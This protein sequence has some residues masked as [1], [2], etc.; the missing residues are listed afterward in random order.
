MGV[1]YS[2]EEIRNGHIP[3]VGD[4]AALG[5]SLLD[6]VGVNGSILAGVVYGSTAVDRASQ[7]SDVDVLFIYRTGELLTSLNL[8]KTALNDA[9][10]NGNFAKDEIHMEPSITLGSA[11]R[12]GVSDYISHFKRVCQNNTG[13]SVGDPLQYLDLTPVGQAEHQADVANFLAAKTE[14]FTKAAFA[15]EP[16]YKAMQRALELPVSIARKIQGLSSLSKGSLPSEDK[17]SMLSVG[18]SILLERRSRSSNGV[19]AQTAQEKLVAFDQN[20]T[21]ALSLAVR[22]EIDYLGFIARNYQPVIE[23]AIT[24]SSAWQEIIDQT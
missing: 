3:R 19:D 20:Y 21:W 7:R 1:V 10:S 14:K 12:S 6:I 15:S 8:A 16:D 2:P 22:G 24:L 23:T 4:H 5:R 11:S 9:R 13:W 18:R 17:Q